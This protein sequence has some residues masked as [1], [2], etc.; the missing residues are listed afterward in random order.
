MKG[1]FSDYAIFGPSPLFSGSSKSPALFV[2]GVE[3]GLQQITHFRAGEA[4]RSNV[5]RGNLP[6]VAKEQG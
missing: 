2:Y 6:N 3:H 5:F 1:N 4:L